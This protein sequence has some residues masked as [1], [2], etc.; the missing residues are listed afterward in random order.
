[1][2]RG[3]RK[4]TAELAGLNSPGAV[5]SAHMETAE[6]TAVTVGGGADGQN[7]VTVRWR[8]RTV[9]AAR[10]A[11]YSPVVGHKVLVLVQGPRLIVIDRLVGTPPK[12]T[13]D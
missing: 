6:V 5:A 12:A 13:E 1:M 10:C 2:G 8:G 9:R 7:L 4:V 3:R 11:S